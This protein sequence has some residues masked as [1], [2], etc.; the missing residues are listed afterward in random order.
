MDDWPFMSSPVP[1]LGIAIS[2]LLYV[3]YVGPKLM[4]NRKPFELK[5]LMLF[6]NAFCVVNS[7]YLFFRVSDLLLA[8]LDLNIQ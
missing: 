3:T 5:Y 1:V 8:Q 6:Y 2:Y 7:F 4:K